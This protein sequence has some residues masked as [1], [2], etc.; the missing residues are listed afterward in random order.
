MLYRGTGSDHSPHTPYLEIALSRELRKRG[1]SGVRTNC[2]WAS[3]NRLQAEQ[4]VGRPNGTLLSITPLPGSV[5]AW[6]PG[7]PDLILDLEQ[8]LRNACIERDARV[9][10]QRSLI[11]VQGDISILD[12]YAELNRKTFISQVISA[13]LDDT[14]VQEIVVD[15]GSGYRLSLEGHTGEVWI[16]GALQC[17]DI[18][19]TPDG[20]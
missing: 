9:R 5:I 8:W 10:D 18:T 15:S 2:A 14:N 16:T 3:T 6:A 1:F 11:D 4:Y 19:N 17:V 13:Y 12:R 20:A 7:V